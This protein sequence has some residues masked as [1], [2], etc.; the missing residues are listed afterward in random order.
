MKL[1]NLLVLL[2]LSI[3]PFMPGWNHPGMLAS[4]ERAA[5]A[6][7]SRVDTNLRIATMPI[8]PF[9]MQDGDK[10]S[11]YSI[12]VWDEIAKRLNV[13]YEWV[14]KDT[15]DELL[16]SIKDGGTEAA[17]AAISM[18]PERDAY[19][20]FTYPYF[21]SGLQ[22]M[23]RERPKMSFFQ[24]ISLVST[25]FLLEV[26]LMGLLAGLAMAHMIWLV[27]RRS[28]PTFP[29]GY[30]AGVWEGL[31]WLLGIVAAGTYR[32]PD[33]KSVI[34]RLMTVTFWILGVAIV[35]EFTA[36]L[37]SALTIHQLSSSI[38]SPTDL[39]GYRIATVNDTTAAEFLS[40]HQLNFVGVDRI[41]EAYAKLLNDE[42]DAI[43]F[44]APVLLYYAAHQGKGH[45]VVPGKIFHLEKYGI[46]VPNGAPLREDINLVLL[47]LYQDGTLETLQQKWFGP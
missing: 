14:V 45:V 3:M 22:I 40:Q 47:Q 35:A 24:G 17:I 27:E 8:A 12:D 34:K 32:D 39:P 20:D 36:T 23:V 4:Q 18:T 46:A 10:L 44:D 15:I 21:D 33:T 43:V 7:A 2:F 11:G 1:R 26:M 25:P 28:N 13:K 9:I 30:L 41:E 37:T 31:W 16:G 38:T 6:D 19:L 42:V 5:R 29:R